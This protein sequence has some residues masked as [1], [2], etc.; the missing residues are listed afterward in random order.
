[1]NLDVIMQPMDRLSIAKTIWI[2]SSQPPAGLATREMLSTE[3]AS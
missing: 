3:T 1:M 2:A